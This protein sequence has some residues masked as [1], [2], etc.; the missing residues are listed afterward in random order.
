MNKSVLAAFAL[1]SILSACSSQPS[2]NNPGSKVSVDAVAPGTRETDIYN[3][4]GQEEAGHDAHGH[5]A[6]SHD[7][8]DTHREDVMLNHDE[9]ASELEATQEVPAKEKTT[10]ADHIEN[11]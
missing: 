7:E 2:D 5:G 9:H 3:L 8:H 11:H 10:D 1:A 6:T 4:N